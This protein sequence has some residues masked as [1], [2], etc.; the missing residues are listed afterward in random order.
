[1]RALSVTIVYFFSLSLLFA[2]Q[3]PKKPT[4]PSRTTAP[5]ATGTVT[6]NVYRNPELGI[7]YKVLLGWVDRSNQT[8]EALDNSS[9]GETLLAVFER[10]PEVTG[11]SINSAVI[12]AGESI[13]SYP[14]VKTAV[15]YFDPLTAAT[16]SQGFKVVNEPYE[17]M[18]GAKP[19][20]RSDFSKEMG[21]LTMHQS[22][23]VM[24]SKG[25][26]ISFTFIGSSED[27]VEQLMSRLSFTSPGQK[28]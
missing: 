13:S 22:S 16:T 9:N 11:D 6:D 12:I 2:Q 21:K 1:M 3:P 27:E 14:G 24:L 23:L 18:V 26:A 17:T 20:V 25:Y 19:L 10:P 5:L 15:D 28:H 8:R 4:S 7:T